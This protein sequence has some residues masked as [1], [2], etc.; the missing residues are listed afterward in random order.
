MSII[1]ITERKQFQERLRAL[2]IELNRTEERKRLATDL[3][4]NLAQLLALAMM[5]G[6]GL[7]PSKDSPRAWTELKGLLDEALLYTRTL[8]AD[9]RPTLLGAAQDL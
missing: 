9:L 1:D 4:D 8:M 6:E 5:K 2:T 3:H 7:Q